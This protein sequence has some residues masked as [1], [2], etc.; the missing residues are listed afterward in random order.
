MLDRLTETL[1]KMGKSKDEVQHW[2][3][4]ASQFHRRILSRHV[5][6]QMF[7]RRLATVAARAAIP[8]LAARE[9]AFRAASPAYA[10]ALA[11]GPASFGSHVHRMTVQ[12]LQWWMPIVQPGPEGPSADWIKKQRFP[13]LALTQTR[14]VGIG[15]IMLDLGANTGRMSIPRVVLG[16]VVAAYCAEPDPL[17]YACLVG[18]IVD[19]G[20]AGMLMPD[21]VAIGDREGTVTLSRGKYSGGHRVL[22][23]GV[24]DAKGA[25]EP[26][27]VPCVTVDAW[28]RRLG[29]DP[30]AVTFVKVDVQG[31][32]TRVLRGAANLL[33][34]R[35]VAW[36]LEVEPQ[37]LLV[38]GSSAAELFAMLQQH[39]TSFIDLRRDRT[40]ARDRPIAEIAEA[41]GYLGTV[42]N[43]TDVLVF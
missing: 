28:M 14:E 40:G 17:N 41:L 10:A 19:N 42:D 7:E 12:G 15:G 9:A 11:E 35:H 1:R 5:V 37:L 25:R 24:A 38:A 8:G 29:V 18:N 30:D 21:R 23:D 39:F 31:F 3:D 26:I 4:R 20:L 13:F 27:E 36:Q 43:K 33:A 6:S 2:K 32:E 34:R 16:D 22:A